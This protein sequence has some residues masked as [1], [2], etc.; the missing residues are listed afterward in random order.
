MRLKFDVTKKGKSPIKL[1]ADIHK[2]IAMI[3]TDDLEYIREE[4]HKEAP[5]M[6]RTHDKRPSHIHPRGRK[7]LKQYLTQRNNCKRRASPYSGYIFFDEKLVPHIKFVIEAIASHRI[8][9]H[10]SKLM[11]F[12]S[13]KTNNWAFAK[14]V[15]HPGNPSNNFIDDV[16]VQS[17]GHIINTF[18]E[19]M[20]RGLKR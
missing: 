11:K 3:V 5:S 9:S 20:R 1:N 10:G 16:F 4:L 15:D 14:H 18:I 6:D 19:R 12:W 17:Y 13:L 7:H 2:E 8:P